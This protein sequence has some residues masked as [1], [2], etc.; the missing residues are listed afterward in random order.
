[1]G[2]VMLGLLGLRR[3]IYC[4]PSICKVLYGFRSV[5]HCEFFFFFANNHEEQER[6]WSLFLWK[7]SK[8]I[9]PHNNNFVVV[10]L[11]SHDPI[12]L[13]DPMDCS[14][15]G[16]PVPHS[17][18]EF[19]QVHV[20]WF[21]SIQLSHLLLLLPSVFPSTRVFS[22]ESVVHIRWPKY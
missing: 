11:L 12:A 3:I 2:H 10:Q 1:M 18:P 5:F 16:F 13:H 14:M 17:L 20:H 19:A 6:K 21:M 7:R 15:P 22:N 9:I 8:R 4:N